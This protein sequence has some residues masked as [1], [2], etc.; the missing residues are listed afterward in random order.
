MSDSEFKESIQERQKVLLLRRKMGKSFWI[1]HS[2][3]SPTDL[4]K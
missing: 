4:E 2:Q 1:E 3:S